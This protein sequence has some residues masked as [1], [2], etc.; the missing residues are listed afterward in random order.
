MQ[1]ITVQFTARRIVNVTSS[2]I[3]YSSY[4]SYMAETS[5]FEK[6]NTELCIERK[7]SRAKKVA[8]SRVDFASLNKIACRKLRGHQ[9]PAYPSQDA[10]YLIV[11]AFK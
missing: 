3:Y 5:K 11:F 1:L 4:I 6:K 10:F 7:V 9:K 8:G 2:I